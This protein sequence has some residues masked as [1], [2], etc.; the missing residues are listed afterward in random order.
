MEVIILTGL[1]IVG[2]VTIFLWGYACGKH[3][4]H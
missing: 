1:V 3:G 2:A 4:I